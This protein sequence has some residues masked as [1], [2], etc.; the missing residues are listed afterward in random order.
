MRRAAVRIRAD[1]ERVARHLMDRLPTDV[2]DRAA[3][4]RSPLRL[5]VLPVAVPVVVLVVRRVEPAVA[6]VARQLA[7]PG[8]QVDRL[9]PDKRVAEHLRLV[10]EGDD[11]DKGNGDLVG[12]ISM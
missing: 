11:D 8:Q 12:V 7:V 2:D 10:G 9:A 1:D 4:R 3:R 6:R 5:P